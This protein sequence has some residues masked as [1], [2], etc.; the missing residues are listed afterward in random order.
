VTQ[1]EHT[2]RFHHARLTH[3]GDGNWVTG[4]DPLLTA[5]GWEPDAPSLLTYFTLGA[6]LTG[7]ILVAW[8][9]LRG[10]HL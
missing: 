1:P 4:N 3:L 2:D 6:V 8:H 7:C 9:Q 10:W 5:S